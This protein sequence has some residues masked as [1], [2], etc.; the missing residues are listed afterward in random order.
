[1]RSTVLAALAVLALPGLVHAAPVLA[2]A[3]ADRGSKLAPVFEET[4][5]STIEPESSEPEPSEPESAEPESAEPE[6]GEPEPA[7]PASPA[8][9]SSPAP[10]SP[11]LL[12]PSAAAPP[13][14]EPGTPVAASEPIEEERHFMSERRGAYFSGALGFGMPIYWSPYTGVSEPYDGTEGIRS[15]GFNTGFSVGGAPARG[16]VMGFTLDTNVGPATFRDDWRHTLTDLTGVDERRGRA[17][18]V[19]AGFFLQGYIRNFFIR[20]GFS[21]LGVFFIDEAGADGNESVGGMGADLAIG[22]HFPVAPKAALGFSTGLRAAFWDFDNDDY[23]GKEY[24]LQPLVRF[25]VVVF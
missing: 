17:H 20:T 3:H 6:P 25:E 18:A 24:I 7:E 19:G 10:A 14:A 12:V 1:M 23:R 4:T 9:T 21:G 22:V 5:P 15:P 13:P 11:H 2:N 8:P 16:F